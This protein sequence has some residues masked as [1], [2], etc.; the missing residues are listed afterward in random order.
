[1]AAHTAFASTSQLG[2]DR[3]QSARLDSWAPDIARDLRP[4]APNRI[5]SEGRL[6]LGNK[7]SL[8]IYNGSGWSDWEA[9]EHGPDAVSLIRH[10]LDGTSLEARAFATNWLAN[11][12]GNGAFTAIPP[13]DAERARKDREHAAYVQE[14]LQ[15]RAITV[16]ANTASYRYLVKRSLDPDQL[17][18]CVMHLDV[19]RGNESAIVGVLTTADGER[20]GIQLGHISIDGVKSVYPPE[21][22]QFLLDKEKAK[23]G[24]F[25]I[26]ATSLPDDVDVLELV[27]AHAD[28]VFIVEGLEDALSLHQAFPFSEVWGLPG[29]I[30]RA[31][32]LKVKM[33]TK[34]LVIADADP[35]DAPAQASLEKG[36]DALILAGAAVRLAS[37]P[38]GS[39]TDANDLLRQGGIAA[40]HAIVA[41]AVPAVLSPKGHY[42][43]AAHTPDDVYE[44]SRKDLAHDAGIRVTV[45]DRER[46]R[47]RQK[48][49]PQEDEEA[50]EWRFLEV[51]PWPS[52]ITDIGAICDE[53]LEEHSSYIV[54]DHDDLAVDVIW[55]LLTHFVMHETIYLEIIPRRAIE[56]PDKR[57]GKTTR[58]RAISL[59]SARPLRL[60]SMTASFFFRV[61]KLHAPTVCIDE[62]QDLWKRHRQ[63]GHLMALL[64]SGHNREEALTG[65]T[66]TIETQSGGKVLAPRVFPMFAA[67]CYTSIGPLP[68]EQLQ[69]RAL[70][71]HQQRAK[72]GDVKKRLRRNRSSILSAVQ[73]KFCRWA[74]DQVA[75]PEVTWPDELYHRDIDNWEPLL[76]VATLVGGDWPATILRA[77]LYATGDRPPSDTGVVPL[78]ADIRT[79]FGQR[80]KLSSVELCAKLV[81]LPDPSA[82]WTRA[83]RGRDITP[84]WLAR[85]LYE[86]TDPKGPQQI[87]IDG[88]N[89]QGYELA[90]FAKFFEMYPSGKSAVGGMPSPASPAP[91][92]SSKKTNGLGCRGSENHSPASPAP[93]PAS[94]EGGGNS[95]GDAGDWFSD[96]LHDNPLKSQGELPLAGDTV[97]AGDKNPPSPHVCPDGVTT[98]FDVDPAPA[99]PDDPN[100][101]EYW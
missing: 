101:E 80:E 47:I 53:A 8:V 84:R 9:G 26:P 39:K 43:K 62:A 69:D 32:H 30:G 97:D 51:I 13:S 99:P 57:C 15:Q 76:Q 10:L 73:Q 49:Q 60:A 21:R 17:P 6:R 33:G 54:A 77:A 37:A 25:R 42:A 14:V 65:L 1:V 89:V 52:A 29:G 35:I 93:S 90:Q 44:F 4:H 40:I 87:R 24:A 48:D 12:P 68:D 81:G 3:V 56:G 20:A 61:I 83:Y 75:L 94:A 92:N 5:D 2:L 70:V 91:A 27:R 63:D 19:G 98:P 11:H 46:A 79:V 100:K 41:A 66:E 85:Q 96:P 34:V 67:V 78:L 18:P 88:K 55:A 72:P 82:E 45:L 59:M 22:H 23:D 64:K 50:N 38:P 95:A 86:V 71:G 7:G 36:L 58:M 74:A 16:T 28:V 31:T